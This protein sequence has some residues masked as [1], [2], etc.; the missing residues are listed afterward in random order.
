MPLYESAC[1]F[2]NTSRSMPE[3]GESHPIFRTFNIPTSSNIY[4][5][6]LSNVLTAALTVDAST[7]VLDKTLG[8]GEVMV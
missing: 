2:P 5:S 1:K 7:G 3:S 8:L 4:L 6:S